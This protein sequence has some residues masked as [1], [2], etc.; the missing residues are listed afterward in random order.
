MNSETL[1]TKAESLEILRPRG[2]DTLTLALVAHDY[3]SRGGLRLGFLR[4]QLLLRPTPLIGPIEMN[5]VE[6]LRYSPS[7]ECPLRLPLPFLVCT[8]G[9][10]PFHDLSA[11]RRPTFGLAA[12]CTALLKGLKGLSSPSSG[13]SKARRPTTSRP[14]VG[15]DRRWRGRRCPAACS[16]SSVAGWAGP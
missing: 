11:V 1:S 7:R 13:A 16:R 6:S 9:V 5:A 15:P 4:H 8:S 2:Q 12:S 3:P 10:A 14:L